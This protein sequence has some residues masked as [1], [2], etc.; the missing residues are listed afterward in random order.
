[1]N[2]AYSPDFSGKF[3]FAHNQN[4]G[5]TG[6]GITFRVT[7]VLLG[8]EYGQRNRKVKTGTFFF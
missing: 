4:L 1:M 7:A 6:G 8:M 5:V 3:K 2:S